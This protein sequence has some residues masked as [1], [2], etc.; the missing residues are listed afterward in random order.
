LIAPAASLGHEATR[1][2]EADDEYGRTQ[3]RLVILSKAPA[4]L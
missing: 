4:G 2:H 1:A 3:P